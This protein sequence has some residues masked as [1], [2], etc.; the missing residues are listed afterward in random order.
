MLA[1]YL[2][3]VLGA[4]PTATSAGKKDEKK[5]DKKEDQE[6]KI[7]FD[8]IEDRILAVPTSEGLFSDIGFANNKLFYS[9][10]EDEGTYGDIPWYNFSS[11][12]K[13]SIF[14]YDFD[15]NKEKVFIVIFLSNEKVFIRFILFFN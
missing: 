5:D 3:S 6:T 14:Y 11:S 1:A 9:I 15:L 4:P 7:D 8:G 10:H 13:S 12:D 2:K